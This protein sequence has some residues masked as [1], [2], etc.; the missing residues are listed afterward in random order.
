MS[1]Q[2]ADFPWLL[3]L[4]PQLPLVTRN[5]KLSNGLPLEQTL[6]GLERSVHATSFSSTHVMLVAKVHLAVV[7]GNGAVEG[8]LEG[9]EE[10]DDDPGIA[11]PGEAGEIV[12]GFDGVNDGDDEA[13]VLVRVV[14]CEVGDIVMSFEGAREGDDEAGVMGLAVPVEVG[15]SVKGFDGAMDGDDDAGID[16]AG[17]MV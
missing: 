9:T 1:V 11:E 10:G 13:G 8:G 14:A 12:S 3:E 2:E 16:V 5:V 4:V 17:T 6:E 15:D 7:D